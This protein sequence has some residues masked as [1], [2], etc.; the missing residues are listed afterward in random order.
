M[1]HQYKYSK[2]YFFAILLSWLSFSNETERDSLS[3]NFFTG[4][5]RIV[6]APLADS[7]ATR[8]NSAYIYNQNNNHFFHLALGGDLS[9]WNVIHQDHDK[10][11]W[12]LNIRAGVFSRFQFDSASFDLINADYR[13]GLSFQRRKNNLAFELLGYHQS[14]HLGDETLDVVN[15]PR[16]DFSYEAIKAVSAYQYQQLRFYLALEYKLRAAPTKLAGRWTA[17]PGIEWSPTVWNHWPLRWALHIEAHQE[18]NWE[19][20]FSVHLESP[21]ARNDLSQRVYLRYYQGYSPMGQFYDKKEKLIWVGFI[22]DL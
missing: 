13:G 12:T 14:S 15:T 8:I 6:S 7:R 4:T 22:Y 1:K 10:T 5:K 20:H 9:L 3:Q 21:L 16:I 17:S 11:S 18:Y 2:F 19:G